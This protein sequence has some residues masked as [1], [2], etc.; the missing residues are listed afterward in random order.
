MKNVLLLL[1][2]GKIFFLCTNTKRE[3]LPVPS[4]KPS[5]AQLKQIERKFREI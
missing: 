1:I 4:R 2:I 3:I 5:E